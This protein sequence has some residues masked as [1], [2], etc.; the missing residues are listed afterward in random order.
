MAKK[1]TEDE[2]ALCRRITQV[3]CDILADKYECNIKLNFLPIETINGD[4][5]DES[6]SGEMHHKVCNTGS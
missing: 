4:D 3:L 5:E 1:Y 6:A 2:L